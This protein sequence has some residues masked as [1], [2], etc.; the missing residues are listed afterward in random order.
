MCNVC[1]HWLMCEK[2]HFICP[3]A[4]LPVTSGTYPQPINWIYINS[5][6]GYFF[7]TCYSAVKRLDI[8]N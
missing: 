5:F 2:H 8:V 6:L 3:A 4:T 7:P 1:D